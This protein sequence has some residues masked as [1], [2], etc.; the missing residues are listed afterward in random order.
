MPSLSLAGP[1]VATILV[2][3]A[4]RAI[5]GTLAQ[6]NPLHKAERAPY[7]GRSAAKGKRPQQPDQPDSRFFVPLLEFNPVVRGSTPARPFFF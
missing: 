1:I 4:G 3:F 2:R 7:S 5:R 6:A